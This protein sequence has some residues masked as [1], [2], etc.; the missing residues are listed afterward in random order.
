VPEDH[1]IW[2]QNKQSEENNLDNLFQRQIPS[3][4]V[5]YFSWTPPNQIL[6]FL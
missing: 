4:I 5:L 3:V 1:N 6:L 2:V